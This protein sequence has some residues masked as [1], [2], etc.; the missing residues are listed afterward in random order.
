[1]TNGYRVTIEYFDDDG[2]LVSSTMRLEEVGEE[3]HPDV[4]AEVAATCL[5]A[6]V[7]HQ[8][9]LIEIA[10]AIAARIGEHTEQSSENDLP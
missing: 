10:A 6:A 5:I 3:S 8:S 1:M 9:W 4:I 7:E 2:L